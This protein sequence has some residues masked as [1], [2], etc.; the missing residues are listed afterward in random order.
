MKTTTRLWKNFYEELGQVSLEC[1]SENKVVKGTMTRSRGYRKR[2]ASIIREFGAQRSILEIGCGYG[3]LAQE[4]MKGTP[5]LYT[6]VDNKAMLTQ[7]KKFLGDKVEYIEAEKI[8]TLRGRKFGLFISHYCLSETPA[9]YRRYVLESIVK[10][11]QKVSIRDF[12][13]DQG[14]RVSFGIERWL[15]KYFMIEKIRTG[16]N[17]SMYTGKRLK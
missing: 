2:A 8:R 16:K 11:C 17:Q 6:V 3:G 9:E 13:D 10:N 7:A 4:I 1:P 12:N 14:K 5:V 15:R